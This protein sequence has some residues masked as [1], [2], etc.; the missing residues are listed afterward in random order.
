M[1]ASFSKLPIIVE[2]FVRD[3]GGFYNCANPSCALLT[4]VRPALRRALSRGA[5]EITP[6]LSPCLSV[7]PAGSRACAPECSVAYPG[8][9]RRSTCARKYAAYPSL[10]E[11]A[12]CPYS[13]WPEPS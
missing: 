11:C 6:A 12:A 4:V 8:T 2:D 1:H 5:L 10:I 7:R 3:K 9:D 13:E